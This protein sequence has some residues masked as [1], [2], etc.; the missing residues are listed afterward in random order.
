MCRIR[1]G[2]PDDAGALAAFLRQ[3]VPPEVVSVTVVGCPG[4]EIH[5]RQ[6]LCAAAR[7]SRSTFWVAEHGGTVAGVAELRWMAGALFL[8]HLF[9]T[10]SHQGQGLGS[11]L[12]W[13][14]IN[15]LVDWSRAGSMQ[16]ALDVLEQNRRARRWYQQ[17]G[18][19]QAHSRRWLLRKRPLDDRPGG[20][21]WSVDGWAQA[22]VMQQALGFSEFH[23]HSSTGTYRVGRLGDHLYRTRDARL[24]EDPIA[25][26]ALAELDAERDLLCI[27]NEDGLTDQRAQGQTVARSL[28]LAAPVGV[29]LQRL[30]RRLR[31]PAAA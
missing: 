29:V 27:A 30:A 21:R 15:G 2:E 31:W 14:S 20:R 5:V 13:Y 17:L 10:P 9:V 6:T 3:E 7:G 11:R 16:L 4:F 28:R 24:M 18:L 1:P 25:L 12:L 19:T 22:E 8:N 23:L 26:G